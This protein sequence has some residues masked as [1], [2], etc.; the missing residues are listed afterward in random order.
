MTTSATKEPTI[1]DMILEMQKICTELESG[2]QSLERCLELY[3]RGVTIARR[4]ESE[5]SRVERRVVELAR[6][7]GGTEPFVSEPPDKEKKTR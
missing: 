3:E 7:D 4:V 2:K 6:P 5:L 1:G